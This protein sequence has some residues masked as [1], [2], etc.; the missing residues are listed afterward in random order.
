MCRISG[1]ISFQSASQHAISGYA[2]KMRD[3]MAY[4]GPDDCGE[5][6]DEENRIYMGHRRLA[7]IDVSSAGHQPM[8]IGDYVIVFN[9]EIYNFAEIANLLV[10]SGYHFNSHSDTEVIL[11]AFD[12]WG[13]EAVRHFRGMFA[14]ALWNKKTK[15]LLLCRDRLGVKPMYWYHNDDVF[16]FGSELKS[17]REFP[18]F[19]TEI[20]DEAVSLFLQTGYIKSPYCIYKHAH[21]LEPGAFLEVDMKGQ[22][23]LWKYWDVSDIPADTHFKDDAQV[24]QAA[25]QLLTESCKYRMV[26]DV[27]VG[28]FL[29]GGID[30]SLIT[31]LLQKQ[32]GKPLK[33]FTI[34]FEDKSFDESVHARK[35]AEYLGT[36]HQELICKREDFE[37]IIPRLPDMYD[38]PFGDSS[39][40]PT[41][42]VSALARKQ[43]TVALSADGGDE[44]FAGYRKYKAVSNY[45][46]KLRYIPLFIRRSLA[47]MLLSIDRAKAEK[48][49]KKLGISYDFKGLEWRLP[50]FANALT[51]SDGIGFF[52]TASVYIPFDQLQVLHRATP[53]RIFN[54]SAKNI[55]S[56]YLYSSL[57]KIDVETY[58]EGD[59]LA[60]V[61]RASMSVAL[62]AREPLLD[63]KLIE[64]GFS[65]PDK[66]KF[67]DGKSKWILRNILYRHLPKELVERPKQGFAIP[68]TEWL[69][70]SLRNDLFELSNDRMFCSVFKLN[71]T[72]LQRIIQVFLSTEQH[73]INPHFVWFLYTLY[74][75]FKRWM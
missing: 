20:S 51:A 44:I 52:E 6:T 24:L 54:H 66:Y 32:A 49:L 5:F 65:L 57:G 68:I 74:Q 25:E 4:G 46:T 59:I 69:K 47:K 36:D 45:Y 26:A 7:V 41:Y 63:H 60:K 75:W 27:P 40:I 56:G 18:G 3:S 34:G 22:K 33:T 14:F 42:L 15:K 61:D 43:V 35:I 23:R 64:F 29:S 58:L 28:I 12:C 19:N 9:G 2:S 31:A 48:F 71:Q 62:E 37:K 38:E 39:S 53:V 10:A 30:S 70:T 16:L 8:L 11:K 1:V 67:R 55:A 50:K 17:L 73:S 21:K 13:E 72:E